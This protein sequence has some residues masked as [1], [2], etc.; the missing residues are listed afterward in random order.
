MFFLCFLAFRLL[1]VLRGHSIFFIPATTA[2]DL[3]LRRIFYPRFY[4]LHLFSYPNSWERASI[5]LLTRLSRRRCMFCMT[6]DVCMYKSS[7]IKF[8]FSSVLNTSRLF[9]SLMTLNY[10]LQILH[11]CTL[12]T[13][14]EHDVDNHSLHCCIFPLLEIYVLFTM[15]C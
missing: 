9:V 11:V 14:L 4:Q 13:W 5:S 6:M 3:R 1:S 7:Q 8:L 15:F 12:Q 2:N 10:K